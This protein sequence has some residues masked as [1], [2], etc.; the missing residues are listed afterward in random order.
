MKLSNLEWLD[1]GDN[2]L[3]ETI[4]SGL[5]R[6]SHLRLLNLE[7]NL[8]SGPIPAWLS[9]NQLSNL[10]LL[11]LSG[12]R[13]SGEIPDSLADLPN[14]E[15][16]WL[17]DNQFTGCTPRVLK[18]LVTTGRG[19]LPDFCPIPEHPEE[20]AAL[21][22]LYSR[23][24]GEDSD[25]KREVREDFL[26]GWKEESDHD[27]GPYTV[28]DACISSFE[29]R[30]LSGTINISEFIELYDLLNFTYRDHK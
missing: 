25:G 19:V 12:N 10:E 20:R 29:D 1:L 11:N 8:L 15:V 21:V 5:S 2:Q 13:L 30:W 16:L 3:H 7:D 6:L 22:A 27:L 24:D 14:L 23:L 28:F 9:S 26:T 17:H 18:G 4:P